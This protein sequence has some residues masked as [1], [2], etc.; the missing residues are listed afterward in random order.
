MA[1]RN[2]A[3]TLKIMTNLVSLIFF[4]PDNRGGLSNRPKALRPYPI[5]KDLGQ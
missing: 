1:G 2:T 5:P 4:F 3:K